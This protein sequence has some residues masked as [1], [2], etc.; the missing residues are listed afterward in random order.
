MEVLKYG[1]KFE[2]EKVIFVYHL[3]SEANLK[4]N[5]FVN[6]FKKYIRDGKVNLPRAFGPIFGNC[7]LEVLFNERIPHKDMIVLYE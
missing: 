1:P 3:S 5:F 7:F 4:V 2:F 6:N